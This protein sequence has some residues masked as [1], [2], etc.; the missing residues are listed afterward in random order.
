MLIWYCRALVLAA[1][2]S[3]KISFRQVHPRHEQNQRKENAG[4][5]QPAVNCPEPFRRKDGRHAAEQGD[6]HNGQVNRQGN[7]P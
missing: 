4:P 3:D 6:G 7:N 5:E 2:L 1:F